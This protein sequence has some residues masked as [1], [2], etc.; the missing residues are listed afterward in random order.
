MTKEEFIN[1]VKK[2]AKEYGKSRSGDNCYPLFKQLKKLAFSYN[3]EL[4]YN[5]FDGY[6]NKKRAADIIR[7]QHTLEDIL[8]IVYDIGHPEHLGNLY[9]VDYSQGFALLYEG[10]LYDIL[11][12]IFKLLGEPCSSLYDED[13]DEEDVADDYDEEDE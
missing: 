6:V 13:E 4:L 2:I 8:D 11:E 9:K 10:D 1:E 7:R 3:I 5:V 12:K